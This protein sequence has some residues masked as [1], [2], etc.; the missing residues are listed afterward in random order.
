MIS[1]VPLNR[2]LVAVAVIYAAT[3]CIISGLIWMHSDEASLLTGWRVA[4]GGATLLNI[5]LV[6]LLRFAWK[7]IWQRV[8][9]LNKVLFPNLNGTWN[10]EIHWHNPVQG[11]QGVVKAKAVI[12]Q[13]L[14]SMSM[15]V[16]SPGSDS[17]T[18]IAHPKKDPESGRP[19][20]FYVYRV[21]PK[22]KNLNS[23]NEYRGSALLKFSDAGQG[24]LS[25]NYFTDRL[26][27]GH[28]SLTRAGSR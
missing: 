4:L 13:T 5:L 7:P 11:Q 18:L 28:F 21:V 2:L 22:N 23:E 14:T 12:K 25:G 17:E 3:V 15:E 1:L 20:L 16:V 27:K 24:E 26:T 10:M 9:I 19:Q 8:A 6:T